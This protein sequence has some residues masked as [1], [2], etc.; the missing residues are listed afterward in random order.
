MSQ[1][2]EQNGKYY[3]EAEVVMLETKTNSH[4]SI[5]QYSGE[6]QFCKTSSK[7]GLSLNQH[8]YILSD[9]E[10]KEGDW[11]IANYF[12]EKYY[13]VQANNILLGNVEH[14]EALLFSAGGFTHEIGFCKKIIATTDIN[15]LYTQERTARG[16]FENL[17]FEKGWN[18]ANF[19]PTYLAR[20]SD[21]FIQEY[22]EEYNQGNQIK[23][24]FVEYEKSY[25]LV[26]K[27]LPGFPEDDISWWYDKLK[28]D[29][30]NQVTLKKVEPE[31][32]TREQ[33]EKLLIDLWAAD[34]NK[35]QEIEDWIKEN[36]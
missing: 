19:K 32:Y 11:V 15:L 12:D 25:G 36:L 16:K 21:S 5:Q 6:L 10:I 34:L 26:Q 8:L 28:V 29:S 2:K 3:Q 22:I 13:V 7:P 9:E 4:I 31:L 20:L 35:R 24:V 33:V 23:K 18:K 27:G 1:L 14:G 17:T 30:N